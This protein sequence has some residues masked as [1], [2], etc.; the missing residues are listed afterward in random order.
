[1]PLG[2]KITAAQTTER[3][4]LPWFQMPLESRSAK[5]G[6]GIGSGQPKPWVDLAD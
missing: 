3:W 2:W 5:A 6:K 4:R 1:M